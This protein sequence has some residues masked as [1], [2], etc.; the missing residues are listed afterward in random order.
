LAGVAQQVP[1]GTGRPARP[2]SR[3]RESDD[4][5]P[6]TQ[7]ARHATQK[8]RRVPGRLTSAIRKRSD[9]ETPGGAPPAQPRQAPNGRTP[10]PRTLSTVGGGIRWSLSVGSSPRYGHP[11]LGL[12]RG[13]RDAGASDLTRSSV[14]PHQSPVEGG[15]ADEAEPDPV[16]DS[17]VVP[18]RHLHDT[19]PSPAPEDNFYGVNRLRWELP[20][21]PTEQRRT[22]IAL[23]SGRRH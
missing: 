23:P 7:R 16:N 9:D 21:F 6:A 19:P 13:R 8:P 17:R 3:V 18:Q 15:E 10:P 20:P 11:A 14:A 2:A 12:A 4:P 1:A 5:T 22:P